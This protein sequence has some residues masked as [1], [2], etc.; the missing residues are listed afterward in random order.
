VGQRPLL[1]ALPALC[2]LLPALGSNYL[3]IFALVT[4]NFLSLG[5]VAYGRRRGEAWGPLLRPWTI[6]LAV[7]V[8][9]G[10]ILLP[11]ALATF[12]STS[13]GLAQTSSSEQTLAAPAYLQRI[14][15]T[16]S[17][18]EL[19]GGWVSLLLGLIMLLLTAVALAA[20]LRSHKR[21]V[22]AATA[23]W[24]LLPIAL[25]FLFQLRYP[26][27][28]PRFLLFA[29]P[30]LYIL[31]AA[32][33]LFLGQRGRPVV[34]WVLLILILLLH[35][36][37]LRTHYTAPPRFAEDT[38]WP[39]LFATIRPYLQPGDGLIARYPWMPGY[40]LAYLPPESQPEWVLGFFDAGTMAGDLQQLLDK[41]GRIWQIDY[42]MPPWSPGN[43]SAQWLRGR[44]A[45]AYWQAF[46]PGSATLFVR[47]EGE[48]RPGLAADFNNGVEVRWAPLDG[49]SR[50]GD[51]V[52]LWLTWSTRRPL[53]SHLV[54]FLHLMRP[55]GSLAAQIDAEPA[56][57]SSLSYE[58]PVGAPLSDPAA[59]L[60]PDDLAN[61]HY[62]LWLGLYDRYTL[63]RVL[64][65]NGDDHLVVGRIEVR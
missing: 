48:E 54:R 53:D 3:A 8:G 15:T 42:Q 44:A 55:D 21:W 58:W 46:E 28:Y 14:L 22:Y 63:E 35:L 24:L 38:V 25:G 27:F 34:T 50:P 52:A 11:Y 9:A 16:F 5:L 43:D 6:W 32:A 64:L 23:V 49:R 51:S 30:A 61:G 45:L 26:W 56:Q 62:E 1:W 4:L 17:S 10:L 31:V 37:L 33:L 41:H 20:G 7:Q 12:G 13:S 39:E 19:A 18:G 59:L 29:Q 2:A 65:T 36:P 60:L 40:M 57:G 47:P